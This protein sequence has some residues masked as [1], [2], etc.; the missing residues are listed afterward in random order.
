M[1]RGKAGH[2]AGAR[3]GNRSSGS[4]AVLNAPKPPLTN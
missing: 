1:T 2:V 3:C 4:A